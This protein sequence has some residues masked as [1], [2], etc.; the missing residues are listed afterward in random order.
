[1]E[2]SDEVRFILEVTLFLRR[3]TELLK[4]IDIEVVPGC[5]LALIE[6]ANFF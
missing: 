2:A 5:N 3:S 6:L 1:M 4:S